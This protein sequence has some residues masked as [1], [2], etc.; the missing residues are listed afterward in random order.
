MRIYRTSMSVGRIWYHS[1]HAMTF[2]TIQNSCTN[3]H[4]Y[5][6]NTST[7]KKNRKDLHKIYF[8]IVWLSTKCVQCLTNINKYYDKRAT[9]TS[10]DDNNKF[11]IKY[12]IL[13]L[14]KLIEIKSNSVAGSFEILFYSISS[15]LQHRVLKICFNR[16]VWSMNIYKTMSRMCMEIYWNGK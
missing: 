9:W 3:I 5:T 6:S 4:W 14:M 12:P 8:E 16:N 11:P 1:C 10:F 7:K 2:F 15:Y 13:I